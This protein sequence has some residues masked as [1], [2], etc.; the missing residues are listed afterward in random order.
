MFTRVR[1]AIT[2]EEGVVIFKIPQCCTKCPF[3]RIDGSDS[4][5]G[6]SKKDVNY[7]NCKTRPDWCPIKPMPKRMKLQEETDLNVKIENVARAAWNKC[8]D[9]LEGNTI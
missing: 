9:Y 8:I 6:I 5:C 2:M 1:K 7:V 3:W 4:Y